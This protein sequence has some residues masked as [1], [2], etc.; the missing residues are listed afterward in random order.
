MDYGTK[1]LAATVHNSSF[2][3]HMSPPAV[4]HFSQNNYELFNME[5]CH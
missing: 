4:I 3:L 1:A 5:L 2:L